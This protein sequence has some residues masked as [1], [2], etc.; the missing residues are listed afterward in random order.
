[1]FIETFGAGLLAGVLQDCGGNCSCHVAITSL[2]AVQQRMLLGADTP[3]PCVTPSHQV[4]GKELGSR[5]K[6]QDEE[7][8]PSSS[9]RAAP[10]AADNRGNKFRARK[11]REAASKAAKLAVPA[12]QPGNGATSAAAEAEPVRPSGVTSELDRVKVPDAP[13]SKN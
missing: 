1:M 2:R 7:D 9:G 4:S 6:K 13:P 5:K 3:T 10:A 11:A 8:E 12:A